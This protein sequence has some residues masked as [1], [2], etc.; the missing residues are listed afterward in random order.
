MAELNIQQIKHSL[1]QH[2]YHPVTFIAYMHKH[3]TLVLLLFK[4]TEQLSDLF[5]NLQCISIVNSCSFVTIFIFTKVLKAVTVTVEVYK[6]NILFLFK[7]T[8]ENLKCLSTT[9]I[10]IL[11]VLS[12]SM[13][14]P[15]LC[16]VTMKPFCWQT[17][18]QILK[19]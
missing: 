10:L 3:R 16:P 1:S 8:I 2:I 14:N 12:V 15:S 7:L 9:K 17:S 18:T 5:I 4:L 13:E 6:R 19:I 11:I